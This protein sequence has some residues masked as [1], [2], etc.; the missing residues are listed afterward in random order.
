MQFLVPHILYGAI[1][2]ALKQS[3]AAH[4]VVSGTAM[5]SNVS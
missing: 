4:G 2:G 5:A 3:I 1:Y